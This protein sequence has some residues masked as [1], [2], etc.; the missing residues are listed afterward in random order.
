MAKN[1]IAGR[2]IALSGVKEVAS[3]DAGKAPIKK[4]ELYM[5]C[6]RYDPYGNRSQYENKPLL[7][8][9]GDKL[10]AKLEQLNIEKDDIVVVYFDIQGTPYKDGQTGKTKVF[11]SVRPYDIEIRRKADGSVPQQAQ[12]QNYQSAHQ[13]TGQQPAQTAA[14]APQT[15]TA[16]PFPPQE[17]R[18]Q[19]EDLP[20]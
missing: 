7:E 6:T 12:Q 14:P 16:T 4:R 17:Q 9:G 8:F 11:T 2:V 15:Q 3:K 18:E 10:L 5:D 1:E 13:P 20:F 19:S